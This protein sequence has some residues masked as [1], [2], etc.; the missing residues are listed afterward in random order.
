MNRIDQNRD[1]TTKNFGIAIVAV[2]CG[3]A[4]M[5]M[6]HQLFPGSRI[7]GGLISGVIAVYTSRWLAKAR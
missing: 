2:I 6:S 3:G 1:V 4:V 5:V 7:V